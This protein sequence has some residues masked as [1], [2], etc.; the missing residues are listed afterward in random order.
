MQAPPGWYAD[1]QTPGAQRWWDGT[2]WTE[3]VQAPQP[4]APPRTP[5]QADRDARQW[6][7]F[8]HLSAF[9]AALVGLSFLGPLVIYLI[10]KDEHPFVADHARE[11]LNFNI[12]VFIYMAVTIILAVV[13]AIVLVGFLLIPV[14]IGIGIAWLV[15]V[16]IASVR[17]NSGQPYR[18][19][20]TI[21]MVS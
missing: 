20:L 15:L 21:R 1:P 9:L 16:I 11:A 5:A 6:G 4:Y 7:M 2:R 12:S 14:A 10:K 13:L 19:P 17:A 8:A 18:Y 3:Q